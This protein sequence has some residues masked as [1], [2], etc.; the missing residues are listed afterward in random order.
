MFRFEQLKSILD[1]ILRTFDLDEL[2]RSIVENLQKLGFDRAG[3][4]LIDEDRQVAQGTWATD[5]QG[6]PERISEREVPVDFLPSREG[7]HIVGEKV[8]KEKLNIDAP[9]L[10]LEI[11]EEEKFRQLFGYM[12]SSPGYY[13]RVELGDNFSLPIVVENKTIGS[14]AVDNYISHRQIGE[15]GAQLFSTFVSLAGIAIQKRRNKEL[16]KI[17]RLGLELN[18]QTSIDD[19]LKTLFRSDVELLSHDFSTIGLLEGDY[20]LFKIGIWENSEYIVVNFLNSYKVF[21]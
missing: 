13:K 17:N 10:F 5:E 21:I 20:L 9:A 1:E 3:V 12:P 11:G 16:E 15:E 18:R 8:L 7:Y 2:L 6:N 14:I 4:F 19:I